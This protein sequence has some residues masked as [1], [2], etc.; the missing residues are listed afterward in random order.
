MASE[1]RNELVLA[2]NQ[3]ALI[4]DET[5]GTVSVLVGPFKQG[6]TGTD[7]PVIYK[8]GKFIGV[9]LED[10]ISQHVSVPEGSYIVLEN[11]A[12]DEK[13][14]HPNSGASQGMVELKIGRKINI[15]GPATF[16]LWPGQV[17]TPIPGHQLKSNEYILVRV[18]NVEEA[19]KNWPSELGKP[20]E[21]VTGQLL[22]VAGTDVNFF[23]PPTGIEV[24]Q[25]PITKMQYIRKAVTLERLE[26]CI[27]LD[28]NGSKRYEIGPK[29]VF[30]TATESFVTRVESSATDQGDTTGSPNRQNVKFKAIELNDQ[31]GLY[32]KVIADY[33][34][35]INYPGM[36][37]GDWIGRP[38][39]AKEKSASDPAAPPSP[40]KSA[41]PE[42]EYKVGD[43]LFITGKTQRIYYPRPEHAIIEYGSEDGTFKR[44]RYYGIAIPKGEA[45]YVLDKNTGRVEMVRGEKIFLPDPRFQIIVRR[46]LDERTVALW[47]PDP[48]RPGQGNPEAVA[49]NRN[50][51]ELAGT[52]VNYVQDTSY[53]AAMDLN[54]S[55]NRG[56]RGSSAL[57]Q[58]YLGGASAS[59]GP[60]A[61]G[62]KV[63][64]GGKFTPPPS[65][66]LNTKYDGP[67]TVNVWTGYAVQ[68]VDKSGKREVVKGPATILLEYDQTLEKIVLS[69]GNPKTTDRL[70]HDV[71][72]RV[73]HNKV[74]DTINVETRDMVQASIKVSYRVNFEGDKTK[75]FAVEN[76]VKFMT[77]HCRSL[78]RAVAKTKS[79]KDLM[80]QS[81]IIVRDT[82]LGTKPP[83]GKS[84]EKIERPGLAFKENGMR[85]YDVEVLNTTIEDAT[86]SRM[87]LDSQNQAV[88]RTLTLTE[89]QQ[90]QEQEKA[91]Q[92]IEQALVAMQT[93]TKLKKLTLEREYSKAFHESSLAGITETAIRE[94]KKKEDEITLA[95]K[96]TAVHAEELVR[97]AALHKEEGEWL[98]K[99]TAAF[100]ER[101]GAVDPKLVAVLQMLADRGLLTDVMAAIAPLAMQE[102]QGI[103]P[104][105]DRL[106]A[107]TGF[108]EKV[109]SL[110][111]KGEET[112]K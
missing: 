16:A 10:A 17:A 33:T 24:V 75:F 89:K 52:T 60:A 107:G 47:Y 100:K 57:V 44:Q 97:L 108:A 81:S 72:L 50:L 27:L 112:A 20:R 48:N 90:E 110:L 46:V 70:L 14:I 61:F 64:R 88:K 1:Q 12:D 37:D 29:V 78:L 69:S 54:R 79:I 45:R 58:S 109:K 8:D 63:S 25:D 65:L 84:E 68:V 26:Y 38:V 73:D 101:M 71:Y 55:I 87:I 59:A 42:Y 86:V 94:S 7:R 4:Q 22:I 2:Q 111:S 32:V 40:P 31:M 19:K 49:Y 76:Y 106:F 56:T 93:E 85:I 83:A 99:T 66:T 82:I 9:K 35:T 41:V 23:M 62:D 95:K 92:A 80:D 105:L 98:L 28:Q 53:S 18:Y 103:G 5:K 102:Q 51:A 11:P 91:I 67:P 30:P 3:Y 21:L 74:S 96:E 43:E 13:K 34:D 15:P 6:L 36:Y 77:D 104:V 39:K